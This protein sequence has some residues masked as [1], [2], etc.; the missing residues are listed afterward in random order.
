VKKK[1]NQQYF[2]SFGVI[3]SLEKKKEKIWVEFEQSLV[4][5][6]F[7]PVVNKKRNV[8]YLE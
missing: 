6:L 7:L 8:Y 3:F 4:R 1:N 2:V 5:Y